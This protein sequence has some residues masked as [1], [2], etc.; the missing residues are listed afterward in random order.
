MYKNFSIF[1]F[2][3]ARGGSK[4]LKNKNS[5]LFSK[6][7]LI[8]WTIEAARQSK[9]I[10]RVIVSTDSAKIAEISKQAKADVP[11]LRPK[12]LSTD[13]ASISDAVEHCIQWLEK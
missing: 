9:Y 13:R 1:A 8:H 6:K 12:H 7:P 11:F 2:I 5:A 10:D 4:G 3:G